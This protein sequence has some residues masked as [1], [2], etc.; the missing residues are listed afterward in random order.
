MTTNVHGQQIGIYAAAFGSGSMAAACLA[1]L[2]K[3]ERVQSKI[4][5]VRTAIKHVEQILNDM[6]DED[7][8]CNQGFWCVKYLELC[9]TLNALEGNNA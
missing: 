9:N 5:R 2:A 8:V 6:T 3:R 4:R 7:P 1:H